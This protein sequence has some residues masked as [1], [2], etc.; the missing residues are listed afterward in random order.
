MKS[1]FASKAGQLEQI[2]FLPN[3][4][5]QIGEWVGSNFERKYLM[6]KRPIYTIAV[7]KK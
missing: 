7:R 1:V 5:V 2:D 4:G 6:E 3:A